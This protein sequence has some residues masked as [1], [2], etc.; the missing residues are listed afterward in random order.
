MTLND[1]SAT[2]SGSFTL[3]TKE[4][5]VELQSIVRKTVA[6]VVQAVA[7]LF[8]GFAYRATGSARADSP[9]GW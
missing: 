1:T 9:T 2:F 8:L 4:R 3:S 7:D 5:T 6:I